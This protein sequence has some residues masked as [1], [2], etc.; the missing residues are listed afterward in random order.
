MA[1]TGNRFYHY[2]WFIL[3]HKFSQPAMHLPKILHIK[4]ILNVASFENSKFWESK[5]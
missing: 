2:Q 5:G 3:T 1:Y 4:G